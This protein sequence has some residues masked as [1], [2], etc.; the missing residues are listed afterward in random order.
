MSREDGIPLLR[1]DAINALKHQVLSF[2][3]PHEE[4]AIEKGLLERRGVEEVTKLVHQPTINTV[5]VFV[6]GTVDHIEVATE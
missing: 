4:M 5:V 1:E 3:T 6:L 2:I